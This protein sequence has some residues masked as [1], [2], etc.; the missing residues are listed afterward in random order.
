MAAHREPP[1]DWS[2]GDA[3]EI[4][5]DALAV[6]SDA[7]NWRL[8]DGRWRA[9]GQLL[10][11]MNAAVAAHDPAA[12]AAATADL[13]LAGPVRITRIGATDAV[14]AAP[15]VRDLLNQLVHSLG[16]TRPSSQPEPGWQRR[17]PE[18]GQAGADGDGAAGR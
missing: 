16:G 3:A 18:P 13:E 17:D 7:L 9:V 4:R 12:L 1:D 2:A 11:A 14:Y 5:A 10:V 15:P 8:A 6:I